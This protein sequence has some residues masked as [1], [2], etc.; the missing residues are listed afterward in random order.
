MDPIRILD[1]GLVSPMRSQAIYHGVACAM[2]SETPDTI[3][4]VMAIKGQ[5]PVQ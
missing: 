4:A 5:A 3:I 1:V 2:K